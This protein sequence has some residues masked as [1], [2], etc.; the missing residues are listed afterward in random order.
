[1]SP[2]RPS[3][4]GSERRRSRRDTSARFVGSIGTWTRRPSA[5]II[6]ATVRRSPRS[7]QPNW[8]ST[9]R[10]SAGTPAE[11]GK[12]SRDRPRVNRS[13]KVLRPVNECVTR[14]AAS[15]RRGGATRH[16]H[17]GSHRRR[18]MARSLSPIPIDSGQDA[19]HQGDALRT[20][21]PC[22]WVHA[23]SPWPRSAPEARP[24]PIG[25]LPK[26]P[27]LSAISMLEPAW[28]GGDSCQQQPSHRPL[29]T[30]LRPG[31]RG[32]RPSA[33]SIRQ[34]ARRC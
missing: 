6:T 10:P 31:P 1:M 16:Q 11:F 12:S 8:A 20:G 25:F 5:A 29:A 4:P 9:Q 30:R 26:D 2:S 27:S 28:Q 34:A 22:P 23:P 18:P 32:G 33:S 14:L 19:T 21:Q 3:S 7:N 13:P 24:C 15:D 17:Q